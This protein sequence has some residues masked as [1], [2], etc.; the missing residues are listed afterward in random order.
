[1]EP[2][3]QLRNVSYSYHSLNG[4]TKTLENV[5][6]SIQPG[7]FVTIVGPS[8]CGKSTLL[9]LICGLLNAEE[10]EI[11]INSSHIG[12]MLQRDH[13]LEWRSVYR[14]AILGLELQHA[15][16]PSGEAHVQEM[17]KTYGLGDFQGAYPSSL[18]G[19]MRQ[20]VALIRT[21]ALEP[22]L[23]LLDEPFSALDYQ[24]RLE[25][26]DDI[27]TI[28]Q[29]E[30]KTAL[31]VTHDLSEAISLGDRVIVLS[32]RPATIQTILPIHFDAEAGGKRLS[33][34][35]RRNAKE[36]PGYFNQ[37]WKEIRGNG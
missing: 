4:E 36:F 29:Q 7:E 16:T 23:L 24:T 17:L 21:L 33:P 31:L 8:G 20:R 28:I 35:S 34:L 6:F 5:C 10:G 11:L 3:L 30:K 18:S 12:Y 37:I 25:V 22:E 2:I 14:N 27:G 32:Q 1:M 19:G 26:S 15:L 13:L 9:S